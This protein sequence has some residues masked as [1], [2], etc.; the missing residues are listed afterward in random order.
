MATNF[1][2]K[3]ATNAYECI[4]T[5]DNENAMTYNRGFSWSANP[6]KTFLIAFMITSLFFS[7]FVV[8]KYEYI[9]EPDSLQIN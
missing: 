5:R 7:T 2:T 4:S 8:N 1:G 3:I 9:N 6:K